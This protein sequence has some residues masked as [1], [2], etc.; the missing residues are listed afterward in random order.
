[1]VWSDYYHSHKR[2]S[3]TAC[4]NNTDCEI[5]YANKEKQSHAVKYGA[6]GRRA[7]WDTYEEQ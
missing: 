5:V 1:M 6:T 7:Y 4:V 3:S 2:H